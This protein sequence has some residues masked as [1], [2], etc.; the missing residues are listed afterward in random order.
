MI[1][2]LNHIN[3]KAPSALLERV[4]DFYCSVLG[5]QTGFRPAFQSHGYW[6]YAGDSCMIHLS[7]LTEFIHNDSDAM[8]V[9]G[10]TLGT[11]TG[12]LNHVA[13]ACQDLSQSKAQL[14]LFGVSYTVKTVPET[15]QT[16][17]FLIDPA[18]VGIELNF[19]ELA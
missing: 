16:Q 8:A 13:F 17:L 18:G 10:T 4:R 14:E 5:L 7:E 1:N 9:V 12:Y 11:T 6:L 19:S 15:K 2:A 3:I